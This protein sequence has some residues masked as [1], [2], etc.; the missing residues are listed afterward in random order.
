MEPQQRTK[1]PRITA[2]IVRQA[3]DHL[4][5]GSPYYIREEGGR[6]SIRGCHL[7]VQRRTIQ[8]GTRSDGGRR[9]QRVA[10]A[11]PDM[12]LEEVEEARAA[13]RRL[14]RQLE[15][16]AEIPGLRRGR[17]MTLRQL[18]ELYLRDFEMTRGQRRSARTLKSYRHLWDFHLLPQAGHLRLSEISPEYVSELQ[19]QIAAKASERGGRARSGGRYAANRALQQLSAA[20]RF[21]VAKEWVLR[22][23][24]SGAAV[25]RFEELSADEFLDEDAYAAVGRVIRELEAEHAAS[26][27][28]KAKPRL[29]ALAALRLAIY[30]GARHC[31]ELLW[32]ELSWCR[33]LEGSVP[34]IGIPRA[35]GD[36]GDRRGRWIYLGPHGARLVR[37]MERPSGSEHLLI[38]G[39]V[40]GSPLNR[41]N[42]LWTQ[43]LHR[44][45]L[46]RMTVKVLRHSHR[47]H[48]VV[49][50]IP[51]EHEQQLLGHRGAS[52]TDTVYLHRH[53]PALAGAAARI[54]AHLRRLMGDPLAQEEPA[55]SSRF[56][57]TS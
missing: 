30:T 16:E 57:A 48:A 38:P 23:P 20:F 41:L 56:L 26:P 18:A 27:F 3:F 6:D 31:E 21:A 25:V 28:R 17:Q 52:V 19:R 13:V 32:A 11:R 2:D 47:T 42:E 54:E 24:A 44:A 53:G 51:E 8:F 22:N 1:V 46:P 5:Q 55:T 45:G 36:R 34:R 9:W 37:E 50:G 49:A 35:K 12:T 4:A 29:R 43:V 14:V 7:R 33:D 40:P 10:E 15:D 39:R